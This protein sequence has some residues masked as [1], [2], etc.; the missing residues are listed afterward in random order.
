[1]QPSVVNNMNIMYTY[2]YKW[3]QAVFFL[4]TMNSVHMGFQLVL[5]GYYHCGRAC[6]EDHKTDSCHVIKRNMSN[7]ENMADKIINEL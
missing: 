1:M 2:I 3:M 7:Y 4:S 5:V 6:T